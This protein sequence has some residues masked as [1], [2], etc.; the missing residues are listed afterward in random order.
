MIENCVKNDQADSMDV[1]LVGYND[2]N[3]TEVALQSINGS[4]ETT[5][6][7]YLSSLNHLDLKSIQAITIVPTQRYLESKAEVPNSESSISA[8][9]N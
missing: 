5:R 3:S 8:S 4:N 1:Y 9:L 7:L 2:S 6:V